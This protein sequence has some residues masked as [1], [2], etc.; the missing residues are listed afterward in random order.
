LLKINKFIKE[1]ILVMTS[2]AEPSSWPEYN[3]APAVSL[4]N[5]V[6]S[7]DL[8]DGELFGDELMDIY[9]SAV[10]ATAQN[11]GKYYYP[12]PMAHASPAGQPSMMFRFYSR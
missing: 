2:A 8:F 6:S 3:N 12:R 10:E 4:P 5:M 11:P 1:P 7:S 9:N